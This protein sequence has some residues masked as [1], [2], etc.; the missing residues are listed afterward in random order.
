MRDKLARPITAEG[1]IRPTDIVPAVARS[2]TLALFPMVFGFSGHSP[3]FNARV[4]TASVKP[5]WKEAWASH[6]CAIPFSWYYEW[7]EKDRAENERRGET[8]RGK[9]KILI[10]PVGYQTAYFA[11]LYRIEEAAGIKFPAF[12]IL[13]TAP[14]ASI[15]FHDRM[16]VIL[17]RENVEEWVFGK[18]EDVVKRALPASPKVYAFMQ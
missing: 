11:G 10:Q 6:R 7:R 13:T 12:T 9:E 8:P 1:E 14:S 15:T 18:P 3:L 2:S 17:P 16:P 5:M 4:E